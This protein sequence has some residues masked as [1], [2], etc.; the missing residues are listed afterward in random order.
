MKFPAEL[1]HMI[2]VYRKNAFINRCDELEKKLFKHHAVHIDQCSSYA[3]Y[4]PNISFHIEVIK[5]YGTGLEYMT[6]FSYTRPYRE[7]EYGVIT[8]KTY[9]KLDDG[10]VKRARVFY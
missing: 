3:F 5:E 8:E 10:T 4:T 2:Y 6:R 9:F 1:W 7:T